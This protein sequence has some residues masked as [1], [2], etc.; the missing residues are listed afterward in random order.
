MAVIE[1]LPSVSPT[2]IL[3]VDDSEIVRRNLQVLLERHDAWK[4]CDEAENGREAIE[5]VEQS[6]F[7]LV[8]LDLQM[9]EMNGLDAARVI[10]RLNPQTPILMV[11]MHMSAQLAVEARKVGIRGTCSKGD[12]HCVV[13]AVETLL[14]HGTY[15]PN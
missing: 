8:I 9:P 2:R 3:L 5:K 11:T 14:N 13:Q 1:S 7:D 10:S 4:I 15:F 12:I 6:Q